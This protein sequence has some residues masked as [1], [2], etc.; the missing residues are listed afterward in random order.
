MYSTPKIIASLDAT[1]VLAEAFGTFD[2][3]SRCDFHP[4]S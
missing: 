4:E 1:A 2:S 3:G